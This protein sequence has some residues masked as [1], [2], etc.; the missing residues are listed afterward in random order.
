MVPV[1]MKGIYELWPRGRSINWRL[2]APWSGH[3]V[4]IEIAEP[5][6]LAGEATD[7]ENAARLRERVNAMWEALS[8]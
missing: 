5:I 8:T 6:R 1:A 4:M 2:L 3:R 7:N